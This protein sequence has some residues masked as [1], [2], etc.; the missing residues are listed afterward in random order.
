MPI[1]KYLFFCTLTLFDP[2]N[3]NLMVRL[4]KCLENSDSQETGREREREREEGGDRGECERGR[5]GR[6][7][8][9]MSRGREK[10]R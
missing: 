5:E 9:E 2:Q 8:E 4:D 7:R 10:E 1:C 6:E 3:T